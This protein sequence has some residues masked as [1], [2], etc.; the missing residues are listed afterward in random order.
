VEKNTVLI[1]IKVFCENQND[2]KLCGNIQKEIK[3]N[4]Y[5]LSISRNNK[6]I[7][8]ETYICNELD[9]LKLKLV[10][11]FRGAMR[12][13]KSSKTKFQILNDSHLLLRKHSLRCPGCNKKLLES[14]GDISG[15]EMKCN[16]C[17]VISEPISDRTLSDKGR[18]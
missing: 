10:E 6:K 8:E 16:R 18:G 13:L 17:G 12:S 4:N 3:K 15:I 7:F 9:L 1:E 5:S 14:W 2:I 11:E